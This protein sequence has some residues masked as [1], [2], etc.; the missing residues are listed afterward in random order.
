MIEAADAARRAD[1]ARHQT[2]NDV[3]TRKSRAARASYHEQ[4]T[5]RDSR[6]YLSR[7]HSAGSY[8]TQNL[9]EQDRARSIPSYRAKVSFPIPGRSNGLP[10]I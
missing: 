4:E 8:A 2:G 6:K 3:A 9:G 7:I 1:D 5:K 10:P